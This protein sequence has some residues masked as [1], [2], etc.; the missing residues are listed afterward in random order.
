M[1][2][3]LVLTVIL[4]ASCAVAQTTET[5]QPPATPPPADPGNG[6]IVGGVRADPG[7][8]P[9][10]AEIF[11]IVPYTAAELADDTRLVKLSADLGFH[12]ES[13]ADWDRNHRCGAIYIGDDWLL[14]AAHCVK[15]PDVDFL[16]ARKVRL[17]TQVISGDRGQSFFVER[18]AYHKDYTGKGTLA[19]DIALIKIARPPG[20]PPF[21]PKRI[22]AVALPGPGD[23]PLADYDS[24]LVTGWGMMEAMDPGRNIMARDNRTVNVNSAALMQLPLSALPAAQ[25]NVVASG[26]DANRTICAGVIDASKK[27]AGGKDVCGGDSGGPLT[28]DP[29]TPG[30]P[31]LLVGIVSAGRGCALPGMPAI[32][33]R[34][35]AYLGW[36]ER[37]KKAPAG[38]LTPIK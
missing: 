24:L 36:I 9:W 31:R 23:R 6:R 15:R 3:Y 8:A 10:Q 16:K 20:A 21:D 26:I 37:A 4:A 35:S 17:G 28:R 7:T 5:S 29:E 32:Y 1:I 33:T 2:R 34:V 11:T 13:R 30:G 19:N 25:C 22:S 38:K 14:T 12:L 27:L 18:A